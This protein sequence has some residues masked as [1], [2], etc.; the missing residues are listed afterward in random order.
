VSAPSGGWPAVVNLIKSF[1]VV[2][3]ELTI[4]L[5]IKVIEQRYKHHRHAVTCKRNNNFA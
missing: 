5:L 4:K 3:T 1:V 2:E